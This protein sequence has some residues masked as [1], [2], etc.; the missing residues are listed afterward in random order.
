[1]KLTNHFLKKKL[2]LLAKEGIVREHRFCNLR[3]AKSIL[4]VYDIDNKEAAEVC[5]E[6]LENLNKNVYPCMYIPIGKKR[7]VVEDSR[8]FI[9]NAEDDTSI[10]M[11]PDH[12]VVKE[13]KSIPAD[14]LIDLT[15]KSSHAMHYLVLS[16]PCQLKTGR[17][18][19]S[20]RLHDLSINISHD[21]KI[22]ELFDHL[23][24]YLFTIKSSKRN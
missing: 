17:K 7:E 2:R 11:V 20:I 14:I 19:D 13:F 18:N 4:L 9:L 3:E 10:W 5:R 24:H 1:M 16:H 23:V 6:K 15:H 8:V 22:T 21:E 12:H